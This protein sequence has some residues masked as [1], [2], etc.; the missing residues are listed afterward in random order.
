MNIDKKEED[1]KENPLP[2]IIPIVE[3]PKKHKFAALI[4]RI[5]FLVFGP[6]DNTKKNTLTI[7]EAKQLP[8]S[9]KTGFKDIEKMKEEK[10]KIE[11][12]KEDVY[13][14]CDQNILEKVLTLINSVPQ[15]KKVPDRVEDKEDDECC[16]CMEK[17]SDKKIKKKILCK[18]PLCT[19]CYINLKSNKCPICRRKIV[20]KLINKYVIICLGDKSQG[21]K[22][23]N[24]GY[25]S[26]NLV[27]L[28]PDPTTQKEFEIISNI[29]FDGAMKLY[30]IKRLNDVLMHNYSIVLQDVK[31]TKQWLKDVRIKIN[32][33]DKEYMEENTQYEYVFC[34]LTEV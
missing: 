33:T 16:V 7:D 29:S 21:S 14:F 20:T 31:N 27:F 2:E 25:G 28:P 22:F 10:L 17:F 11:R 4:N 13:K 6:P 5:K 8:L 9:L 1:K 24:G 34:D 32:P 18:H 3:Q 23:Y 19:E 15:V 30:F 12:M 26:I